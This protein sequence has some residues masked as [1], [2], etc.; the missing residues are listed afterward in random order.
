MKTYLSLLLLL[1]MTVVLAAEG[2]DPSGDGDTL[3]VKVESRKRGQSW[4]FDVTLRHPDTGWDHYADGW[5]VVLPDGTV[6]LR[7][8]EA[9]T[10][11]LLHPHVNE[12][13]FTRSQ[14]GLVI[15]EGV[16]WVWVRGHDNVHGYG[17]A[18]RHELQQ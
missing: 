16:S 14:S 1:S 8:Q 6:L 18:I 15:P 4:S 3:V 10:R 13:P 11:V 5:D 12:Q 17:R 7:G 2:L 9:F